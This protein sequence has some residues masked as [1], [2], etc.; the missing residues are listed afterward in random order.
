MAPRQGP[1]PA[2][3]SLHGRIQQESCQGNLFA[4]EYVTQV[5]SEIPG[6]S[7]KGDGETCNENARKAHMLQGHICNPFG[8]KHAI[9][10]VESIKVFNLTSKCKPKFGNTEVGDFLNAVSQFHLKDG[11]INLAPGRDKPLIGTSGR[12]CLDPSPLQSHSKPSTPFLIKAELRTKFML[13]TQIFAVS[14]YFPSPH[15]F[16]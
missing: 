16:A 7:K 8:G 9:A 3:Q 2:H 5:K 10:A 12:I 13:G 14:T 1:R 6:G 11:I 4:A 15:T